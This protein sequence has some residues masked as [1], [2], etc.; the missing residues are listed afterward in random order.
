[1]PRD[2]TERKGW[3]RVTAQAFLKDLHEIARR[4]MWD[5]A[6]VP[7]NSDAFALPFKGY[8]GQEGGRTGVTVDKG[9]YDEWLGYCTKTKSET[10][11][12]FEINAIGL[13]KVLQ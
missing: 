12:M 11:K 1:M 9:H 8:Y 5:P 7:A 4:W 2:T 13:D 3:L 10:L 6:N